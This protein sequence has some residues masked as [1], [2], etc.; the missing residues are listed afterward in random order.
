VASAP[1]LTYRILDGV[2]VRK[3]YDLFGTA[4]LYQLKARLLSLEAI[5]S[6]LIQWTEEG[7]VDYLVIIKCMLYAYFL[8]PV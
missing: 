2:R 7:G 4:H 3:G 5:L 8:Y 1:N 6:N